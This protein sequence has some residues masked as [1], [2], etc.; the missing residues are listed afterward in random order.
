MVIVPEKALSGTDK[1]KTILQASQLTYAIG[2][3]IQVAKSF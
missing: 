3:G 2:V 1:W